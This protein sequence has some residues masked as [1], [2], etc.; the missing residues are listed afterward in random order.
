MLVP[1]AI[2]SIVVSQPMQLQFPQLNKKNC[3]LWV[4]KLK[5]KSA[6]NQFVQQLRK[7]KQLKQQQQLKSK[8]SNNQ[9]PRVGEPNAAADA[10]PGPSDANDVTDYT[11]SIDDDGFFLFSKLQSVRYERWRSG[12]WRRR[13]ETCDECSIG[14]GS[15]RR[16]WWWWR[17]AACIRYRTNTT[18]DRIHNRRRR[19][20]NSTISSRVTKKLS[21]TQLLIQFLDQTKNYF[22]IYV[23]TVLL[24]L[25]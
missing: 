11:N 20:S 16:R 18:N 6:T 17:G 22:V 19:R 5:I 10:A 1:V 12:K 3:D 21:K 4:V 14:I 24:L 25:L 23:W 7:T 15:S 8:Q 13:C 9:L 2:E